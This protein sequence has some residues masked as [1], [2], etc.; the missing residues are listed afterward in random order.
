MNKNLPHFS[1]DWTKVLKALADE[2]R[3]QIIHKLLKGE[4]SVNALSDSLG[5]K[6][7]NVSRHLKILENSGL[8]EKR[9]EGN[10]R[11]YRISKSLKSHFSSDRQVL[12][13]DCCQ[14]KF[15]GFQ[16]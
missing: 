5:L 8:V 9:K 3:L 12:D 10:L 6:I 2:S 14:F 7:Y 11:I 13:L 1:I 4:I 15:K 16:K